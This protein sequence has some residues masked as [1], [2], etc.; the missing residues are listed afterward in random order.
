MRDGTN[1]GTISATG[2]E[3]DGGDNNKGK[4]ELKT[5]VAGSTCK[6]GSSF[7]HFVFFSLSFFFFFSFFPFA[8]K[9]KITTPT[10][11]P[12]TLLHKPNP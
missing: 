11:Q 5:C 7:C 4:H 1:T 3:N 9:K 10:N 12:T 2:G 6:L 8:S